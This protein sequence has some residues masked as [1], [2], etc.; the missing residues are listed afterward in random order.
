M[1][2]ALHL[3][4][5]RPG[6]PA[7]FL[8]LG[9]VAAPPAFSRRAIIRETMLQCEPVRAGRVA[10]RFVLGANVVGQGRAQREEAMLARG[11]IVA[12]HASHG[13]VVT[14]AAIDGAGV[15]T[16]CSCG[17]KQFLWIR[18]ALRQWPTVSFV[19]KTEDDTYVQLPALEADLRALQV[20]GHA[21]V[22]FGFMTLGLLPDHPIDRG[23]AEP[24]KQMRPG[25]ACSA[26][27]WRCHSARLEHR[28]TPHQHKP[29]AKFQAW[30]DYNRTVVGCFLGDLE[31]HGWVGEPS[32]DAS[33]PAMDQHLGAW[34]SVDKACGY[35]PRTL[36]PFPTGPLAVFGSD[37]AAT[38]FERCAYSAQ[39]MRE[40]QHW[41]RMT[42]CRGRERH[43]SLASVLGDALL[44]HLVG[45]CLPRGET[46]TV[47]HTTRTKSHH[48]MWRSAGLGWMPPSNLSV[49]IHGLKSR[50]DE[51]SGPN[52]TLG[53]EWRHTH[54][55]VQ[56][57]TPNRSLAPLLWRMHGGFA[58]VD[59]Q[60]APQQ[61]AASLATSG[62]ATRA[63]GG[64]PEPARVSEPRSGA[65][66]SLG[67][68]RSLPLL[69]PIELV[70]H[71]WYAISCAIPGVEFRN[72]IAARAQRMRAADDGRPR[73]AGLSDAQYLGGKPVAWQGFT[74]CNPSRFHAYPSWPPH[75]PIDEAFARAQVRRGFWSPFFV[76]AADAPP[77]EALRPAVERALRRLANCT[78]AT[79]S[80]ETASVAISQQCRY[81]ARQSL[82]RKRRRRRG[83]EKERVSGQE[84]RRSLNTELSHAGAGGFFIEQTSKDWEGAVRRYLGP[85]RENVTASAEVILTWVHARLAKQLRLHRLNT[86]TPALRP[87]PVGRDPALKNF[88]WM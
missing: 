39:Y 49:A 67:A 17:E 18:L 82:R 76:W 53:G 46:A 83:A 27:A 5:S 84:L 56:D 24:R 51:P 78:M 14:L 19:G 63:A 4:V 88:Q 61:P 23:S 55:V 16:A 70:R 57:A 29:G 36:A 38:V 64:A 81:S 87:E 58:I 85:A 3:N 45:R 42:A 52:L 75:P 74:G 59:A 13:D 22:M 12:E 69:E 65:G 20:A 60:V 2:D 48:Y 62:P 26:L 77:R 40:A 10:F 43:R 79:D 34:R 32:L 86:S 35:A 80:R 1:Q 50:E 30:R 11:K 66:A 47:A 68:R 31:A 25:I 21:N 71:Y 41:D 7:P 54:S 8:A 44:G 37:L 73:P 15:D 33:K 9:M 72:A 28:K 6:E